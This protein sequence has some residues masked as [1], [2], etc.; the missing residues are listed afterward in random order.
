MQSQGSHTSANQINAF[1]SADNMQVSM[2]YGNSVP[3]AKK[4]SDH[5]VFN[6]K[7][8][9]MPKMEVKNAPNYSVWGGGKH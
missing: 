8:I 6:P 7:D 2:G 9:K 5:E 3:L 4:S 1:T